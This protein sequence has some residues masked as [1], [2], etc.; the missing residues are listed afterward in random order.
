MM[1][2]AVLLG[3]ARA[4]A[5]LARRLVRFWLFVL[6]TAVVAGGG[7]V[8]YAFLHRT[9]SFTSAT[10]AAS[11]PRYLIGLLGATALYVFLVGLV[12]LGFDV[13]AR[14][15]R[16]RIVD[17]LDI[18]P[19]S[20]L[21][22]MAGR[23]LGLLGLTWLAMAAVAAL[24]A[25]IG[26]AFDESIE[27]V[28]LAGFLVLMTIPAFTFVLG[29][30]Y[31]ISLLVRHRG[32]ALMLQLVTVGALFIARL[33]LPAYLLPPLDVTGEMALAYPSD[34]LPWTTSV[35]SYVQCLGFVLAG[36]ALLA[37]GAAVCDRLDDRSDRRAA[38]IAGVLLA[39]AAAASLGGVAADR[40]AD[41]RQVDAWLQ[42]Q[43]RFATRPAP[44]LRALAADVRV[45]PGR[46][47]SMHLRVTFNAPQTPLDQA[48][49]TL[50][51]GLAVQRVLDASGRAL[52]FV[53]QDG[54]LDITLPSRLAPGAQMAVTFEARGRPD[55]RFAYLD[56][57]IHPL[58]ATGEQATLRVLGSEALLFTHRYVALMPGA[59][60]LPAGGAAIARARGD[61]RD[62]F[63]DLDLNVELPH[64]WLAA[65][66]GRR[67]E[68][69]STEPGLRRFR[70]APGARVPRPA[71]I[72]GPFVSRVTDVGGVR[73]EALVS[74]AHRRNLA[75]FEDAADPIRA[76][77]EERLQAASRLGLAYPYDALTVVEVP[78]VLRGYGGTWR[79]DTTQT[80]P[81]ML[82]LREAGWPTARF[83]TG[84]K[85]PDRFRAREGGV[86]RAK[87][88]LLEA[89]FEHDFNGGNVFSG[90][91]R[92]FFAFQTCAT[93]PD[94]PT[95]DFVFD[96]LATLVLTGKQSYFSAYLL[97]SGIGR[98][99]PLVIGS[100]MSGQGT[101]RSWR[102]AIV[103][104]TTS[105]AR[106]WDRVAHVRLRDLDPWSDPPQALD[107]LILKG[108]AMARSLLDT[109]GRDD[110]GRFLGAVRRAHYG[111]GYT[112]QDLIAA[113][114][115]RAAD[116]ERQL[117]DWLDE[118]AL[119]GFVAFDSRVYRLPDTAGGGARFQVLLRLQNDENVPGF[120]RV[121]LRAGQPMGERDDQW[122]TVHIAGRSSLEIAFVCAMPPQ[123]V[124]V[125]PYLSLNR[126][127]FVVPLPRV[128]RTRIVQAVSVRDARVAP[129]NAGWE[130]AV[131]V[132]DLDS[133]FAIRRAG[134]PFHA[135]D[136]KQDDALPSFGFGA[137]PVAWSRITLAQAWGRYRHTAAVVR[138]GAGDRP[139][140]LT[141]M[142][143]RAGRW[144]LEIHVPT[145]PIFGFP[146]KLGRWTLMLDTGTAR[147]PLRFDA[148]N[149][150]P[151]W[152]VLGHFDLGAGPAT[153][154]ISDGT[155]GEAI[156][157]D[158]IRYRPISAESNREGGQ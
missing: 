12:F 65:G 119:P 52:R 56:A 152:N 76:W 100:W 44:E 142:L 69:A 158:A 139:A 74:L 29:L 48:L 24:V 125:T 138:A 108:A 123:R 157:V 104:A 112:R 111:R 80:A 3:V 103:R 154:E 40:W 66:P 156:V 93:G 37:F 86:P 155:D 58:T 50:N 15:R 122:T 115:P 4:E 101:N 11:N 106:L 39:I 153:L 77:L 118:T 144:M 14:D 126:D 84:L 149:A 89:F 134:G 120:A 88:E 131:V 35:A 113:A 145:P 75:F 33:R 121:D 19:V 61:C 1:R 92:N 54:L 53:Q 10:M 32:I 7:T 94:A 116:L 136:G 97:G 64:D 70:F 5:R 49:F 107:L 21:E 105:D 124:I 81:A 26:W 47:L 34:L 27:P 63:V 99:V 110:A 91:S 43:R 137:P 20:T 8:F 146:I 130:A 95:L 135:A 151:G 59:F 36:L 2:G 17:V 148:A 31:F 62:D 68:A 67:Q 71:L 57:P 38:V 133:G 23:L 82:L 16:E 72:A 109:L 73:V 147:Y 42:V 127:P 13:R 55:A 85:N 25:G 87:R 45:D 114:G 22:L 79:M 150:V 117:H 98:V 143:P 96:E 18:R 132:D 30:I 129:Y 83:E 141:A 46:E 78:N 60:W 28:S 90:A 9:F 140:T 6:F 102:D 128:D 51:P 41:W